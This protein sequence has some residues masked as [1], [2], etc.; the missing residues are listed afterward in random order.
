VG[1]RNYLFARS[2]AAGERVAIAYSVVATCHP[3][4]ISPMEYLADV[5][6]RLARGAPV[7]WDRRLD[8]NW[9][10]RDRSA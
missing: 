7:S 10:A 2:H 6:P 5:L 4:G 1:R 9:V 8:R 3:L